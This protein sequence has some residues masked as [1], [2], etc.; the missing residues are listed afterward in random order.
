MQTG[1]LAAVD[2]AANTLNVVYH[3][4]ST[5]GNNAVVSLNIVNRGAGQ[6]DYDVCVSTTDGYEVTGV[7]QT[8]FLESTGVTVIPGIYLAANERLIV[9]SLTGS[10][11][12]TVMGSQTS[13][14]TQ[15]PAAAVAYTA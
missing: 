9:R 7:R 13:V 12:A 15:T 14:A 8:S 3:L 4:H 11:S 6:A 10:L 5:T 2:V 1:R